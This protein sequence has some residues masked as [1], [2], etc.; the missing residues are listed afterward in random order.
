MGGGSKGEEKEEEMNRLRIQKAQMRPPAAA[1]SE[2]FVDSLGTFALSL[3][4]SPS[5]SGHGEEKQGLGT[6]GL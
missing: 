4:N 1:A 2:V 6:K 5:I 3:F